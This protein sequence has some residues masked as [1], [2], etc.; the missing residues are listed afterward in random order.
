MA[1]QAPQWLSPA[2][3]KY[4]SDI[5][6]TATDQ[7]KIQV[8]VLAQVFS[9]Y[10][11]TVG[12]VDP[13]VQRRQKSLL[14]VFCKLSKELGFIGVKLAKTDE[15]KPATLIQVLNASKSKGH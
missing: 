14:E 4:F 6:D 12:S 11:D 7:N 9:D 2:A 13:Q 1:I 10:L 5:R 15:D 8:A 3:K